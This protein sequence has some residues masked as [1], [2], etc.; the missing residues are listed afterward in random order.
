MARKQKNDIDY[1]A[2]VK[3]YKSLNCPDTTLDIL[4]EVL[5]YESAWN[6]ILS[7]RA[8]GKTTNM[9]LWGMCLNWCYGVQIQYIR[10][11]EYQITP[12]QCGSLFD[13]IRQYHYIEKITNGRYN[14]VYY[15]GHKW[16]YQNIDDE[17][18]LVER[19]ETP[20]CCTL[21]IDK[22]NDY[23]SV[24]N[25]PLG[26]IIIVDE[27]LTTTG[28]LDDEFYQLNDLLSTIIRERDTAHI[29]LLGNLVDE[30]S[31]YFDEL[32]L[33]DVIHDMTYGEHKKLKS[34][35]TTM[36][37][38]MMPQITHIQREKI[39]NKY[40]SWL[41]PKINAITGK[42]GLW[43]VRQFPKPPKGKYTLFNR[44]YYFKNDKYLCC[45]LR[46]DDQTGIYYLF[47]YID[48]YGYDQEKHILYTI[49]SSVGYSRMIRHALGYN[50][51]YDKLIKQLINAHRDFYKDNTAGA[52]FESYLR[53]IP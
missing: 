40:F 27:F 37:V 39:N 32:C 43:A 41:N 12:K 17:G 33:N 20:F 10:Q 25:A 22:H 14:S 1:S 50:S 38:C 34:D 52:L 16:V 18:N 30:F 15:R 13:V 2:A 23:K 9:L 21:S 35:G 47:M 49:T 3:L 45:E 46:R 11:R 29:Y 6:I 4:G 36:H 48:D 42:R 5:P 53:D 19:A 31:P 44:H 7:I 8:R 51:M 26:D 24:Y 28:Y